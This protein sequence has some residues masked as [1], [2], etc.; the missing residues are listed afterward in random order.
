MAPI[1]VIDWI[2][3]VGPYIVFFGMLIVY[4]VWEGKRERRLRKRYTEERHGE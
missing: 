1:N 2:G 3:L 4:Y